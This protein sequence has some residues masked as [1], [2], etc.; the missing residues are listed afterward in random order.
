MTISTSDLKAAVGLSPKEND[1]PYMLHTAKAIKSGTIIIFGGISTGDESS[2]SNSLVQQVLTYYPEK[3]VLSYGHYKF[4]VKNQETSFTNLC[5]Y[6][7]QS[8]AISSTEM[9]SLCFQYREPCL[10]KYIR[11][12]SCGNYIF[13]K[14]QQL[15]K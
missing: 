9:I 3:A 14:L 10:V 7:N 13:K 1:L 4:C 6:D 8:S 11:D 12:D 2:D 5:S 15:P